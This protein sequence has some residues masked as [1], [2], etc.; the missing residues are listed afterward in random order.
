MAKTAEFVPLVDVAKELGY[1]VRHV[2]LL[3]EQGKFGTKMGKHWVVTRKEVDDYKKHLAKDPPR[4]G[5]P[6]NP[7]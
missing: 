1:G 3:C 2:R 6:P 5:R 4:P 7:K